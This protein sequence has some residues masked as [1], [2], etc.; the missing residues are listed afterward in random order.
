MLWF[1]NLQIR[2]QIGDDTLFRY[3][4]CFTPCRPLET[5]AIALIYVDNFS[6]NWVAMAAMEDEKC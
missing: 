4:A 6:T 1:L 5:A 3:R 2:K